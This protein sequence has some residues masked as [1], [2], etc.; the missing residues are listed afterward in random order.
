MIR[1]I[2]AA[3]IAKD[4]KSRPVHVRAEDKI[5]KTFSKIIIL[6]LVAIWL[7]LGCSD[8]DNPVQSEA[9]FAMDAFPMAVGNKWVY[10]VTDTILDKVDTISVLA[11]DT[12]TLFNNEFAYVWLYSDTGYT[13]NIDFVSV[14]GDTAKFYRNRSAEP[15]RILVFPIE[16]GQNWTLSKDVGIDT[17]QVMVEEMISVP[18][19]ESNAFR[20]DTELIPRIMD[21]IEGS[22]VW[23]APGVGMVRMEYYSGFRIIDSYEIWE[24]IDYLP[25]SE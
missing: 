12:T 3:G 14:V 4:L 1:I 11:I 25:A 22:S 7:P 15:W 17:S 2:Y 6:I 20:I 23:I 5:M 13:M 8:D 9:P 10:S 18:F 24:L 19:E 16:V 21:A